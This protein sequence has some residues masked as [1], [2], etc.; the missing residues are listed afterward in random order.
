MRALEK[1]LRV[2]QDRRSYLNLD[3]NF[4]SK[5]PIPVSERFNEG[6]PTDRF[7]LSACTSKSGDEN[8]SLVLGHI[9]VDVT[10]AAIL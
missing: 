6:M 2:R 4:Q 5:K 7:S 10:E 9:L 1:R 3:L 8:K